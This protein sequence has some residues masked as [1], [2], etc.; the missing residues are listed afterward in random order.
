MG[1]RRGLFARDTQAVLEHL[2]QGTPLYINNQQSV[3]SLQVACATYQAYQENRL[4]TL[5]EEEIL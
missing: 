1:S 2:Q 4:V 3:Y 5:S